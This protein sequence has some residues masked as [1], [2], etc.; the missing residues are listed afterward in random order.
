M[1]HLDLTAVELHFHC[2]GHALICKKGG[3]I[4]QCHYEVRDAI[5]DLVC[6]QVVSV[7]AVNSDAFDC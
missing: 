6:G 3:L 2:M 5:G 4:I 7:S 1:F